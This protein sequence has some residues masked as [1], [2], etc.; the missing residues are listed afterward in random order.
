MSLPTIC[1]ENTKIQLWRSENIAD[2]Y[3]VLQIGPLYLNDRSG[4]HLA[5]HWFY[6]PPTP[7]SGCSGQPWH[8]L[9]SKELAATN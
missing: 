2:M 8:T 9:S 7:C 3:C 5:S 1:K 4:S 6:L